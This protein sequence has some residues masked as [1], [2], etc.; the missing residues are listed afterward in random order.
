MADEKPGEKGKQMILRD[1]LA[2]NR[3]TLANE[4]TL[5]AYMRTALTMFVAGVT[6]I[7]FFGYLLVEIIGWILIP[8]GIIT[9]I[10]GMISY[11]KMKRLITAEEK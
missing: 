10:R 4:R 7:R 5:L 11:R 2:E 1:I 9:M 6:F 8:V 3:T